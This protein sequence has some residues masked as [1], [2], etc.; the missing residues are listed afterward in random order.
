MDARPGPE[1]LVAAVEAF[2]ER[3]AGEPPSGD[4]A[5]AAGYVADTNALFAGLERR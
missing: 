3:A 2:N 5:W 1:G 4:L